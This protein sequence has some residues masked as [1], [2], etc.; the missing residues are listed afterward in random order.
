MQCCKAGRRMNFMAAMQQ[1]TQVAAAAAGVLHNNGP[2]PMM[3]GVGEVFQTVP[4]HSHRSQGQET[5]T[6][7]VLCRP[8]ST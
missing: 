4:L 1:P 8:S 3:L 2:T 5:T 6:N 7:Q